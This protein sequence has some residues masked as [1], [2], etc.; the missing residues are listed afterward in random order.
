VDRRGVLV[1]ATRF[2]ACSGAGVTNGG[3]LAT[4]LGMPLHL[5]ENSLMVSDPNQL[6]RVR[7]VKKSILNVVVRPCSRVGRS[8]SRFI[9]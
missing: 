3:T 9:V 2:A 5:F 8:P 4:S 7:A 6:T 1:R